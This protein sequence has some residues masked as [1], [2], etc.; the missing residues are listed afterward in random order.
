MLNGTGTTWDMVKVMVL[1]DISKV[2]RR[3]KNYRRL[4]IEQVDRGKPS[5]GILQ[6]EQLW[7]IFVVGIM[8]RL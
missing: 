7:E 5:E 4:L 8:Q 6:L 1:N 3:E 2:R